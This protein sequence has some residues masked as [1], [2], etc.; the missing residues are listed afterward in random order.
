VA[1]PRVWT[2]L[3]GAVALMAGFVLGLAV[4][5][6]PAG[7]V[8]VADVLQSVKPVMVLACV[9]Y[10]V[11]GTVAALVTRIVTRSDGRPSHTGPGND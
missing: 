11:L 3:V 5:H 2:A 9:G 1:Y 8:G 10:A 6:P 4:M 7:P